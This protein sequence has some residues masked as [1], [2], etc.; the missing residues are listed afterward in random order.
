MCFG[1]SGE[2]MRSEHPMIDLRRLHRFFGATRAVNDI[3]FEV[4]RGQVFG[5]IAQI[6]RAHV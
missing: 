2:S 4:Q 6:G 1:A 3:S 5:Y